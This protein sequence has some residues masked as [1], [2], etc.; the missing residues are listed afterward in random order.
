MNYWIVE[1]KYVA[2][3]VIWLR[4]KDGTKGDVD[5]RDE[6]WGEVFESLKDQREFRK[7]VAHPELHTLVWE[8]GADFAPEFLYDCVRENVS[9]SSSSSS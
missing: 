6:L 3:Y 2:D 4:F 1:A 5:L 9:V 8:N 7:F